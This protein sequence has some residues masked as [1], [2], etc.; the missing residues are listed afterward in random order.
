MFK[1][2]IIGQYIPGN[3]LIHKMDPRMKIVLVILF[4]TLLFMTNTFI[5]YGLVTI[6]VLYLVF[7][8]SV[9]VK[10]ILKGL[11]PMFLII[12][13]TCIF[14]LFFVGG[15]PIFSID[16]FDLFI[17]SVTK[18]GIYLSLIMIIRLLYLII[19]TSILTLT[20]SPLQLTHGLECLM[21]PLNKIKVPSH[22]IA[23]MMTIAIRFIPTIAD[24]TDK[25]MKA[26]TA[27]GADFE[28]GNIVKRAKALLPLLVPLFVSAFRR[29]EELAT[30]MEAR[31]YNG[32]KG[33]TKMKELHFSRVD[34]IGGT[35]FTLFCVFVFIA[36]RFSLLF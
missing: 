6:L 30:A 11:K 16:V 22:E 32:S 2:V 21:K 20:T 8:C 23:L 17:I 28:S 25:I 33:R 4:I 34:Y 3:S 15:D 24:E 31:C 18:Q 36:D 10:F 14:N 13:F 29:A 19:G 1:N 9:P 35:I 7:S 12:V 26:Q 27:R 5:G